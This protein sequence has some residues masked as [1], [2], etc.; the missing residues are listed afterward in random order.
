MAQAQLCNRTQQIEN[1]MAKAV[2]QNLSK[3]FNRP[4][5]FE[6]CI[7]EDIQPDIVGFILA[8]KK[9]LF[10]MTLDELH[11]IFPQQ[12]FLG[13]TLNHSV[14]PEAVHRINPFTPDDNLKTMVNKYLAKHET[15]GEKAVKEAANEEECFSSEENSSGD[16]ETA[17]LSKKQDKAKTT[18]KR[19]SFEKV[20]A[21]HY[22]KFAK[23]PRSLSTVTPPAKRPRGNYGNRAPVADVTRHSGL[24]TSMYAL[25]PPDNTNNFPGAHQPPV[26]ELQHCGD[27]TDILSSAVFE[28][29][30]D[31]K[32][33]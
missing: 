5:L 22:M 25:G 8:T 32:I 26:P 17:E 18:K 1:A 9:K 33:K 4:K 14:G 15:A 16:E 20:S 21:P 12:S 29:D 30:I 3:E 24:K 7:T 13:V 2:L 23:N 19:V 28:A 10:C 11:S 27:I 6:V 31:P